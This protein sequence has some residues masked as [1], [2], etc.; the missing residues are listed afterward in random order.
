MIEKLNSGHFT[1]LG[2]STV[3]GITI[4]RASAETTQ[5]LVRMLEGSFDMKKLVLAG[6]SFGGVTAFSSAI[7][8]DVEKGDHAVATKVAA[9]ILLDPANQWIPDHLRDALED[10]NKSVLK[11]IPTLSVFSQVWYDNDLNKNYSSMLEFCCGKYGN[12][13]NSCI[14]AVQGSQHL[15]LCDIF[16]F[17]PKFVGK[18]FPYF[19][20]KSNS[21]KVIRQVNHL[22]LNFLF[23]NGLSYDVPGSQTRQGGNRHNRKDNRKKKKPNSR[24]ARRESSST[25]GKLKF[26]VGFQQ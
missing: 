12:D 26:V 14:M 17:L 9:I 1:K 5:S 19:S 7:S 21:H 20:Q 2:T 24:K 23:L 18:I 3:G 22:A 8:M 16:S 25:L 10:S 11:G 15:G 4:D 6:H 13:E